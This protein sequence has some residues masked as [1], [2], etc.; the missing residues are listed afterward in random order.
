MKKFM[1]LFV[2]AGVL[3]ATFAPVAAQPAIE[4]QM[5]VWEHTS[6]DDGQLQAMTTAGEEEV[7]VDFPPG[8]YDNRAMRCGQDFWSAGGQGATLFA[9]A[10][11]GQLAIYPMDG[12]EAII[13]GEEVHR[14]ACAGPETFQFS[15]NG[16][17][18][19]YIDYVYQVV[20]EKYPHGDLTLVEA[21]TGNQLAA[22]DWTT[23]F[24]LYDDGAL[25]F[26][27]FPDGKG[28]ASEADVDWWDGSGR[29]TLVTLE[30][31]YPEDNREIECGFVSGSVARVGDMAYILAGQRCEVGGTAWR[32]ISVPMDGGEATDVAGGQT[33]GG[34]FP[35]QFP[36]LL[37]PAKD[38]NGFLVSTPS[39]LD[40]SSATFQWVTMDGSTTPL[41]EGL[42]VKGD[43]FGNRLDEGR[44][45]YIS[46]NG[47]TLAFVTETGSGQ[48]SLWMLDLS[49][50][51]AEPVLIEEEGPNQR[52]FQYM[53]AA[54]NTLYYAAGAIESSSLHMVMPGGSPQRL[55][56]GRFFRLAVSYTGDKVAAA[57]WFANP[58]SI[59]DDL[60]KLTVMDMDGQS[61]TV[62]EG[63]K[64]YNQLIPLAIQ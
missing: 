60:F 15:P 40:R 39:G 59:G 19:G 21:A 45:M 35:G 17:Y 58:D 5:L 8:L 12:S 53:W 25:M 11:E 3:L 47:N 57:E 14:M 63:T 10:A 26:R 62:E 4:A 50:P 22:F 51:G 61:M 24:K 7:L 33:R 28:N 29:K 34:Y 6:D 38:N 43:R 64:D 20:D 48:Q 41:L 13:L 18:A 44:N 1:P 49:A 55:Q 54:N 31:I 9:G 56:R 52:I 42:H 23:A 37:I 2:I 32:L 30:P 27:L 36:E 16:Q 46:P